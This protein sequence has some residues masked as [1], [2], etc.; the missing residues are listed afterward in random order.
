MTKRLK[1]ERV[2]RQTW[3]KMKLQK[4]NKQT[5]KPYVAQY[6]IRTHWTDT[7]LLKLALPLILK[8]IQPMQQVK[9]RKGKSYTVSLKWRGC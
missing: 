8:Q 6:R 4:T 5:K 9:I 1:R 3:K 7:V 2:K